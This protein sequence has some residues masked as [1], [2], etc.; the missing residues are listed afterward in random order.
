[1]QPANSVEPSYA[2]GGA[3]QNSVNYFHKRG[4]FPENGVFCAWYFAFDIWG[5]K[6][7]IFNVYMVFGFVYLWGQRQ[8]EIAGHPL[9]V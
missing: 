1:M 5:G 7:C 6:F 9:L 8:F 3:Q 2:L 4:K